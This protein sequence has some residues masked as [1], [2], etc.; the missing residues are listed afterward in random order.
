MMIAALLQTLTG[1]GKEATNHQTEAAAPVVKA[2]AVADNWR[3]STSKDEMRGKVT[4]FARTDSINTVSLDFP[5]QG[6]QHG[7]ILIFDGSVVLGIEKGQLV[8]NGGIADGT[9]LVSVKFDDDTLE[10]VTA[11]KLGDKST[12]IIFQGKDFLRNIKNHKKLMI[13]VEIFQNGY[14]VFTFDISGL[15]QTPVRAGKV[16]GVE[17][18]VV[19]VGA[20]SNAATAKQEL[21][22]LKKWGFKAYTEKVDDK[23]R[24]QA[25]PYTERDKAEKVRKLLEERGLHPVVVE[26]D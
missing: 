23:I 5:Y 19:Q 13:E 6:A 14:P 8:C 3:Y 11:R 25:G 10:H 20:Y 9:C 26:L 15:K 24:V 18:Y 22:K 12:S 16:A 7:N 2:V 4:N 21:D 17:S 1:C